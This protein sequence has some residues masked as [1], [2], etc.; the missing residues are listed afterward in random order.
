MRAMCMQVVLG[1]MMT[2]IKFMNDVNTKRKSYD[3]ED[4]LL[5]AAINNL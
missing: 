5:M 3:C 2:V 4:E 1:L